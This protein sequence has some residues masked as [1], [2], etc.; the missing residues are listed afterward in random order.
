MDNFMSKLS[1]KFRFIWKALQGPP[2]IEEV[3]FHPDRKWRFDFASP[4]K[5]LAIEIEGG[6]WVQGAHSRGAHFNSDCEKYNNA[7]LLG[8]R[9]FRITTN[10]IGTKHLEPIIKEFNK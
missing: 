2:L 8:W 10:M 3:K 7:A 5:K 9:V 4:N 6:I 1:D